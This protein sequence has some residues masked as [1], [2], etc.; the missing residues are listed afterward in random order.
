MT[1][2]DEFPSDI[3]YA[4]YIQKADDMLRDLGYYDLR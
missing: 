1:L 2:P 4:W 3:D